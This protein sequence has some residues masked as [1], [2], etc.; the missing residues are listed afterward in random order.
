MVLVEAAA[1]HGPVDHKR[2]VEL[3]EMLGECE[4]DRV[5]I[6]A[7]PDAATFR[8]YAAEIAWETEGWLADQPEHMIHFNGPKFVGP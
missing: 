8:R 4:L 2:H 6:S 7:F 3:E 1:T 5:Y